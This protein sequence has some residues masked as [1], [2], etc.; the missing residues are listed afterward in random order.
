MR[1]RRREERLS[2]GGFSLWLKTDHGA[3]V[4]EVVNISRLGVGIR[5]PSDG[6]ADDLPSLK[7]ETIF[8]AILKFNDQ[9]FDLKLRLLRFAGSQIGCAF[10]YDSAETQRSLFA[11]L[12]PRFT[13]ST[14]IAVPKRALGPSI[15]YAYFGQ[16]FR[17][18]A[19][20]DGRGV[21]FT[22]QGVDCTL[23]QGTV[24]IHTESETDE[25]GSEAVLS[26]AGIDALPPRADAD[27]LRW[28]SGVLGAWEACPDGL[29]KEFE[30]ARHCFGMSS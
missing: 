9:R 14:L 29:L 7:P 21:V 13:A 5:L 20:S 19:F 26:W 6:S 4:C 8:P 17:V 16:D 30:A 22:T 24:R 12:T 3:M 27:V 11:L 23:S 2:V 1:E 25:S 15:K 18:T 28:I 10:V